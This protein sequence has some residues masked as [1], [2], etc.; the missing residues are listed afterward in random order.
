[1]V[2]RKLS[3]VYTRREIEIPYAWFEKFVS[4]MVEQLKQ[5]AV[6]VDPSTLSNN[7]Q[8]I[9]AFDQSVDKSIEGYYGDSDDSIGDP[10]SLADSIYAEEIEIKKQEQVELMRQAMTIAK[11]EN[12]LDKAIPIRPRFRAQAIELLKQAGFFDA[13]FHAHIEKK[14]KKQFG[15]NDSEQ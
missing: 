14:L 6:D 4:N 10:W 7:P 3:G 13:H 11:M 2:E 5:Q 12:H 1:M 9:S 8:V 15:S